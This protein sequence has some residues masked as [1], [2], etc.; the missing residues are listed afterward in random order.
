MHNAQGGRQYLS[1]LSSY[2]LVLLLSL[3]G[4][5]VVLVPTY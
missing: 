2:I 3:L 4:D 1:V 5:L